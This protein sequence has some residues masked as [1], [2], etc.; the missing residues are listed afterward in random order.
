M[1]GAVVFL[2]WIEQLG[3][4]YCSMDAVDLRDPLAQSEPT[5]EDLK[6][7]IRSLGS[8]TLPEFS[9]LKATRDRAGP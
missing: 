9:R 4:S 3:L 2:R 1:F 8:A 7:R 6:A 5:I